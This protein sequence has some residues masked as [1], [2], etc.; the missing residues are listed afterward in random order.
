MEIGVRVETEHPLTGKRTHCC[1]SYRT[2]ID[3]FEVEPD[4]CS[5]IDFSGNEEWQRRAYEVNI[6]EISA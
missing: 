6:A 3:Q 2:C 1:T 4:R 5:K